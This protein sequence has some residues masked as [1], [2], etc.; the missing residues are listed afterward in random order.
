MI[1]DINCDLGEGF[2]VYSYGADEEMMPLITSA[3]IACGFHGGDPAVMRESVEQAVTQG[4][5][6]GAHVGLDDRIGFGRREVPTTA[7]QAYDLCLYQIGALEAFVRASGARMQHV[8]PHGALYM[9]ANRDPDLAEA[10]CR[11]VLSWDPTLF[12]YVL[13]DSELHRRASDAGLPVMPEIF[14][15]R[16]YRDDAVQMYNRT[17]GDVGDADAV[18]ARTLA[19]LRGPHRAQIAT[20]CMHS[21]TTNAPALLPTLRTA[22]IDAGYS[23]AAPTATLDGELMRCATQNPMK[24]EGLV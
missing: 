8:K 21:D 1:L 10:I 19:Q 24:Q 7:Q 3:N 4:V 13:P 16:P 2:G 22:L 12:L 6:I 14:A 15:D 11:A 18:I 9:M 20:V 17:V 23:F 5:A